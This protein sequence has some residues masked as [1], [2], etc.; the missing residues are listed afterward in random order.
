M[1]MPL[2][3]NLRD[4]AKRDKFTEWV[5]GL[6]QSGLD[7]VSGLKQRWD[8]VEGFYRGDPPN[9][10]CRYWKGA[11]LRHFPLIKPKVDAL[12]ANVIGTMTSQRP[13][14]LGSL[15]G[16]SKRLEDLENQIQFFFNIGELDRVLS[17]VSPIAGCTNMAIVRAS[18]ETTSQ[19]Y[20][21][22]KPQRGGMAYGPVAFAGVEYEVIHPAD[23]VVLGN[24]AYG[25][26]RALGAG[27]RFYRS[28][29]EIQQLQQLGRYIEC[30]LHSGDDPSD[31]EAGRSWPNSRLQPKV[32][33]RNEDNKVELFEIYVRCDLG[34]D[35]ERG[36]GGKFKPK[37]PYNE[38]W[39]CLTVAFQ[40]RKLLKIK[41][42]QVSRP[43]YAIFRYQPPEYGSIYSS[44]SVGNDLQG[45]QMQKIDVRNLLNYGSQY[46]MFLPIFTDGAIPKDKVELQPGFM[47]GA[48]GKVSSPSSTFNPAWLLQ[49]LEWIERDADAITRI[50][51]NATG[52]RATK[53]GQ[54]ITATE[55]SIMGK[56]QEVGINQ[57]IGQLGQGVVELAEITAELLYLNYD[58]WSQVYGPKMAPEVQMMLEQLGISLA[59]EDSQ[60]FVDNPADFLLPV[61]WQLH[62]SSYES[63]PGVQLQK[64]QFAKT[65]AMEANMRAIQTMQPV[66]PYDEAALDEAIFNQLDVLNAEKIRPEGGV[67]VAIPLS[68]GGG[69]PP[70]PGMEG[71]PA[72]GGQGNPGAGGGLPFSQPA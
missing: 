39:W 65:I 40:Q 10:S 13:Y 41:E 36:V 53:D 46:N 5:C 28:L 29:K 56:A 34:A 2:P 30:D 47:Y 69:I 38:K 63:T 1:S 4:R 23:F 15:R 8:A 58:V 9:W 32:E 59:A 17:E 21:S 24:S 6:V 71:A 44:G 72:G 43:P 35:Q 26:A 11:Q 70:G 48:P 20:H 60:V 64:L 37:K 31:N 3:P 62:G 57:Y 68:P 66:M 7:E 12:G 42:L 45:L 27:N 54:P 61:Q 55:S 16:S 52:Q 33:Q 67:P 19:G 51:Q 18:F 22:L 50:P 14:V 25:L 49:E